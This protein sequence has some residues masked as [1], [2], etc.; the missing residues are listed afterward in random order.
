MISSTEQAFPSLDRRQWS[1]CN[2]LLFVTWASLVRRENM[3]NSSGMW[4]SRCLVGLVLLSFG[5]LCLRGSARAGHVFIVSIDGGKPAVISRST[6]PVLQRLAAEG[7]STWT[8]S[9]V[10]PS[11]TLPAH[12]SMLTGVMP[13]KHKI[14]WN[15]WE[16]SAGV[17]GVPTVF[18]EAKAA[19]YGT[20]MFVG[21]EK[22]LH[23][24]RSG[25]VD[26]FSYHRDRSHEVVKPI[27]G[28]NQLERSLSVAARIVAEDASN[29]IR[30]NK[31]N[32]C[33]IHFTDPDDT[34]HQYG[35]GSPEQIRAFG[36]VDAALGLVLKAIEDAGIVSESVVIVTADHGGH[37]KEHGLNIP[38]DMMI[39][40]IVWGKHV[41][42]GI[43]I[44]VPVSTCDTA[45][46]ALWLLGIALPDSFDGKPVLT[47]FEPRTPTQARAR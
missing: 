22:F 45:A 13:A 21:K 36:E 27:A 1:G 20:A 17:V 34:G 46:T 31:P 14:F 30:T 29:Y 37:G 8:A 26:C 44:N 4:L 24:V 33:F 10:F 28:T 5:V 9:T 3:E 19:G 23:L 39:P 6:M 47:A 41:S 16:P 7:S 12:A 25:S 40:W 43:T 32:L 35:W 2:F 11:L 42:R 15:S 18:S 38:E